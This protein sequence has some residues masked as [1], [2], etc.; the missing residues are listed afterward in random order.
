[1]WV[2]TIRTTW[3]I[4]STKRSFGT[5]NESLLDPFNPPADGSASSVMNINTDIMECRA[6]VALATYVLERNGVD[7]Q[8]L[9]TA[10]G[11]NLPP[12][13]VAMVALR[14][15]WTLASGAIYFRVNRY[16]SSANVDVMKWARSLMM[17]ARAVER[18]RLT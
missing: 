16:A 6:F 2:E 3:F 10:T 15:P 9:N 8:Q 7:I 1:M 5:S 17:L 13:D 18:S 14:E 11:L 4:L 12:H